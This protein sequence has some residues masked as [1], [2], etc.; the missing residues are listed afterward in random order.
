MTNRPPNS[1]GRYSEG[2]FTPKNPEKYI[3][4]ERIFYRSSWE[5]MFMN[6]CDTRPDIIKWASEIIRIPYFN[7][8][9]RKQTIYVPDFIIQYVDKHN[10]IHTELIEIKPLNQTVLEKAR[11]NRNKIQ[12]AINTA[13]WNA[14]R[15][16]CK[17]NGVGFRILTEADLFTKIGGYKKRKR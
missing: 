6:V 3:G 13:K 7:T 9:T 16:W 17:A 15:K 12:L 5:L 8:F 10:K 2:E 14:A 1:K 4:S 11:G